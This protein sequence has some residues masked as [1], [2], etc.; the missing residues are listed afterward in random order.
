MRNPLSR[1][2]P[3]KCERTSALAWMNTL[4]DSRA[5]SGPRQFRSR[6]L[7]VEASEPAAP[8]QA[9]CTPAVE[10]PKPYAGH[11]D[12]SEWFDLIL[13]VAG[14]AGFDSSSPRRPVEY[15]G[16][17]TGWGCCVEDTHPFEH[18]RTVTLDIGYDHLRSLSGVSAEFSL[19]I[20][21][22]RFPNLE[23][24]S[25][26]TRPHLRRT[27]RRISRRRRSVR[28]LERQRLDR[29]DVE[30]AG[31]DPQCLSDRRAS[32]SVSF[33]FAGP[34]RYQTDDWSHV[35]AVQALRL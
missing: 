7:K 21:V 22:M 10:Q 3:L 18:A 1:N 28:L 9:Q 6:H 35:P 16:I 11:P 29:L 26:R 2:K 20:P 25:Q 30:Q 12:E 19:M 5:L 34:R 23:R 8:C 33:P 17:R 14:G 4:G 15:A 32:A 24:T 27:G 13:G 31:C